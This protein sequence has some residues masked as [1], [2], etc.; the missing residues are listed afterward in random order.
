M[1]YKLAGSILI[2]LAASLSY[3]QTAK[4]TPGP[5]PDKILQAKKVFVVSVTGTEKSKTGMEEALTKWGKY[6]VVPTREEADL[7]F[8]INN[9][10]KL[11]GGLKADAELKHP[12][13]PYDMRTYFLHIADA[14]TG[15]LLW[16]TRIHG[17]HSR[18][19][20]ARYLIDNLKK[21]IEKETTS[22]EPKS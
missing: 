1:R 5:F 12:D 14:K 11:L 2:L 15:D 18:E 3:G 7:V 8:V 9:N 6:E 19:Q 17:G 16:S 4:D 10:K 13:V 21:R 22:P 20:E